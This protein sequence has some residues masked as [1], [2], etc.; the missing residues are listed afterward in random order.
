MLCALIACCRVFQHSSS[1]H[2]R[3]LNEN[4]VDMRSSSGL[5]QCHALGL[6]YLMRAQ[7]EC[8][9]EH[10]RCVALVTWCCVCRARGLQ[11]RTGEGVAG[12]FSH[13]GEQYH[14]HHFWG[15]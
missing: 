8:A 9:F 4:A 13:I 12:Y 11:Y 14:A 6:C 2:M 3:S 15:R 10:A 7:F 1:D 5:A